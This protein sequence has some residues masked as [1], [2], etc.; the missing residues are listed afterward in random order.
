MTTPHLL[1]HPAPPL[2]IQPTA[3]DQVS[4]AQLQGKPVVLN[5]WASWCGP[6][7][8][9]LPVLSAARESNPQVD[10]VGAAMQDTSR[11]VEAFEMRHAH[12]YPVGPIVEGSYQS[13]GVI[14]P[15][16]PPSERTEIVDGLLHHRHRL[17]PQPTALVGQRAHRDSPSVVEAAHEVL[18]RHFDVGEEH[19][20]EVFGASQVA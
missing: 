7:A 17:D 13:Y 4:L 10:F 20:G 1:G 3:G 5:F 6:C 18:G 11:G 12:P 15:P 14:G 2:A 9:E 8:Q 19:L 16:A